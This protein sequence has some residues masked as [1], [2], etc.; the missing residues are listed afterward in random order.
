[1]GELEW[2]ASSSVGLPRRPSAVRCAVNRAQRGQSSRR[3]RGAERRAGAKQIGRTNGVRGK[4]RKECRGCWRLTWVVGPLGSSLRITS[5]CSLRSAASE[6]GRFGCAHRPPRRRDNP[7]QPRR[8]SAATPSPA[9]HS[10]CAR[11]RTLFK[12]QWPPITT[13]SMFA[14]SA[15]S[16]SPRP[17]ADPRTDRIIAPVTRGASAMSFLV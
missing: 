10:A 4:R 15:S 3:R 6:F 13:S 2:K 14:T 5:R 1:M 8:L 7:T 9:S 16:L 17:C 11:T 12:Q